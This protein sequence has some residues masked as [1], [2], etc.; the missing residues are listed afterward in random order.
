M[1]LKLPIDLPESHHTD[2]IAVACFDWRMRRQFM[3]FFEIYLCYMDFF[4]LNF[5]GGAKLINK[6]PEFI[7]P[8]F[9]STPIEKCGS[10]RIVILDHEDCLAWGGS[11]AFENKKVEMEMHFEQLRGAREKL[12][13]AY[14]NEK[15]DIKLFYAQLI[16]NKR[17]SSLLDFIR[18][19]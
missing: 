19:K 14:P 18:V 6:Y 1:E 17:K 3:N 15:L 2:I 7:I 10:R 11:L 16:E 4:P 12:H 8:E 9:F 5:P 13:K